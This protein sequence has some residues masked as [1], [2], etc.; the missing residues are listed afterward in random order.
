VI[1]Q[2][3]EKTF[4]RTNRLY[5][6][7]DCLVR[8]FIC[9]EEKAYFNEDY[10]NHFEIKTIEGNSPTDIFITHNGIVLMPM[11]EP[12]YKIGV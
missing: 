7:A 9:G 3:T 5:S 4:I 12:E 6:F 8:E 10:I 2:K 11:R 1:P